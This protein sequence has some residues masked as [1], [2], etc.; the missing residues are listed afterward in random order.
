VIGS[1]HSPSSCIILPA[2]K[3]K[4]DFN[5]GQSKKKVWS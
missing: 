5:F 2:L 1:C 3:L 4:S